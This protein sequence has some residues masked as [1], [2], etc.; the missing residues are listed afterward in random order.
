M[1]EANVKEELHKI[2][3]LI[4]RQNIKI[5][6]FIERT[7]IIEQQIK[8]RPTLG[9]MKEFRNIVDEEFKS[10]YDTMKA[11]HQDWHDKQAINSQ[12]NVAHKVG[13]INNL[14]QIATALFPYIAFIVYFIIKNL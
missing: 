5:D 13:F 4:E 1:D 6:A 3:A 12:K 8:D 7:V 11:V 14:A 9:C 2:M 10:R